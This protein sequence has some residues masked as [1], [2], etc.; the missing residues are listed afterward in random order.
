MRISKAMLAELLRINSLLAGII[1]HYVTINSSYTNKRKGVLQC[2]KGSNL[3]ENIRM[4]I[5][6]G[7]PT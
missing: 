1:Y 7:N 4:E 6:H 5:S 3:T 2:S